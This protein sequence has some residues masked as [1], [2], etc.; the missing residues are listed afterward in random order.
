MTEEQFENKYKI[1]EGKV[2]NRDV[3]RWVRTGVCPTGILADYKAARKGLV[4]GSSPDPGPLSLRLP[5][6]DRLPNVPSDDVERDDVS[7][8][9]STGGAVG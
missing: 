5:D 9:S 8:R 2:P 4:D 1:V 6:R 3:I 7:P